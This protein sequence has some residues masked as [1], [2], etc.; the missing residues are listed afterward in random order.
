VRPKLAVPVEVLIGFGVDRA[1]SRTANAAI[2]RPQAVIVAALV[3][4]AVV[5]ISLYVPGLHR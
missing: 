2:V 4:I 5:L 1:K 3:G